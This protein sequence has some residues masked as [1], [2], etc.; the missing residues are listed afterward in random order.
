MKHDEDKTPTDLIIDELERNIIESRSVEEFIQLLS[1]CIN[2]LRIMD[3]KGKE[4]ATFYMTESMMN[5]INKGEK[6]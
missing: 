2:P 5:K 6:Q 4:V 3:K 1:G